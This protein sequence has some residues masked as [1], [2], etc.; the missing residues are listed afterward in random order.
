M[1]EARKHVKQAIAQDAA[2]VISSIFYS[3]V[4]HLSELRK[5]QANTPASLMTPAT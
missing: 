3:V 4:N 1:G 2:P 5:Y